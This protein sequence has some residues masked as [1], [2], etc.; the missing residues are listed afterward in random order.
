M[1]EYDKVTVSLS[2]DDEL[3]APERTSVPSRD[4]P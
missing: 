4:C 2:E 3:K 1:T